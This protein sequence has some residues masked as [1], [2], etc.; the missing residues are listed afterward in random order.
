MEQFSLSIVLPVSNVSPLL[1]ATVAECLT[2]AARH[3]A[4]F[5]IIIADDASTDGTGELA[6]R[7]AAIHAPVAVIHYPRRRGYRQVIFDAWGAARG[8]YVVALAVEGP[9]TAA[10][11]DR[12]LTA[13]ADHAAIF[14]YRVPPPRR[15]A[16]SL[17]ALAVG[18]RLA[19]GM[20]D[21][22]LGLALFRSDLRDLLTPDGRDALAHASIYAEARRRNLSVAQIAVAGKTARPTPPSLA[23]S[24]AALFYQGDSAASAPTASTTRQSAAVGAGVLLAAGGLWLLRRRRR[25]P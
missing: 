5:E 2:L 22:A 14:G 8:T 21:P 13:I 7:L 18:A 23:D 24:A 11:I 9:A 17:F 1:A 6:D 15:P 16:E 12:L 3:T 10:D 4:E 25:H 20:R 19:P